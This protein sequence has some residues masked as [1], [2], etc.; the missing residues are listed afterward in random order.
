[1][2]FENLPP[3]W[4][5]LPLTTTALA[6]DVV[7]L[8]VHEYDRD[9]GC[10]AMLL[11]DPSGVLLQPVVLDHLP[12]SYGES[13]VRELFGFLSHVRAD[14]PLSVVLALGRPGGSPAQAR[15]RAWA[16]WAVDECRRAGVEVWS[17]FLATPGT[18]REVRL[19]GAA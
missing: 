5:D 8:V 10:L 15:I 3:N 11:C 13:E 7:D 19:P 1:M 4:A 9:D 17:F 16:S 2:S 12:T 18:V 6:A 14:R